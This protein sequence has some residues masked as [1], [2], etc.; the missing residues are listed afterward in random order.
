MPRSR[1]LPRRRG[2]H[3]GALRPALLEAA[4]RLL[5]DGGPDAV[6][7]RAVARA[8]GVSQTAPY[9]HFEDHAAL[10]KAV[11]AQAFTF[12]HEKLLAAARDPARILGT[13][14]KTERGVL[15]AI[16]LAYVRFGLDHPQEYRFMFGAAGPRDASPERERVYGFLREGI[17]QLQERGLVRS[18][19]VG[20]MT[21]TCW[22][23]V[24]GLVMLALDGRLERERAEEVMT[25]ATGLLMFGMGT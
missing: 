16:A 6:T 12:L 24:H 14:P 5:R 22:S 15:Q 2:Y 21:L 8:T 10:L 25:I 9:R 4:L 23:L 19:D 17:R 20:A 3:H 11:A 13:A 7:L 18:G 1:S